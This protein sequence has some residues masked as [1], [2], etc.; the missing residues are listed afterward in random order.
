[1]KTKKIELKNIIKD[2]KKAIA[3]NCLDCVCC[4]PKEVIICGIS[5]CSLYEKRPKELK[6]MYRLAKELRKKNLGF[7]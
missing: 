4:Q 5:N 2:Y 6:G 3:M 7:Y 1:M